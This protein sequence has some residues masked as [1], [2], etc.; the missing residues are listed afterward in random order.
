MDL[1]RC[2]DLVTRLDVI[3]ARGRHA[4]ALNACRP[5]FV[6]PPGA[7]GTMMG[8]AVMGSMEE[9]ETAAEAAEAARAAEEAAMF[10][11][12]G[13]PGSVVGGGFD[14]YEDEDEDEDDE[15]DGYS[16]YKGEGELL[17]ELAGLRQPVLAAQA[18]KA[19]A[20]ARRAAAAKASSKKKRAGAKEDD[21]ADYDDELLLG[22]RRGAGGRDADGMYDS[23]APRIRGPVPVD[24]F[25]PLNT[26]S[27]VITGPNTGGKTAAMKA[28]G[29]AALM[30]RAGLFVPA[31]VAN[32]PWFD[33]VL[34]DI[35]DSQDL[36]QS[37]STFSAR[38]AKQRAILAAANT[39]SLVLMDEVGTGT[40]PA[41]GAAIG[42]ALL[43]QL[44]GVGVESFGSGA[45]GLTLATTHHGELKAL[46]YEHKGG[47]FENAAV[48]F[49]EVALAPTYRLLWGVPGR[50][51]ALQIAERFGLDPE[52]VA[53][54]RAALGEGRVTLEETISALESA[55]RGADE[56]IA[57]ARSLL[58]EVSRTVPRVAAAAA[59]VRAA[60]EAADVKLA[61]I[62]AR[63]ARERRVELAA[64]ARETARVNA[65]EKRASTMKSGAMDF[66]TAA[67]AA[68]AAEAEAKRLAAVA[69]RNPA[70]SKPPPG[71]IPNV[72]DAVIITS[73]GMSG[74]VTAVSGTLITVQAG[75]M[76]IKVNASDAEPD[77]E[78]PK[79]K[80]PP[81]KARS[82]AGTQ[83]ARRMDAL[84]GGHRSGGGGGGGGGRKGGSNSA[85][86]STMSGGGGGGGGFGGYDFDD[87]DDDVPTIGDSV[88]I[89]K[90]GVV[91]TVVDADDGVL[92]VQAGKNRLKAPTGAV[93]YANRGSGVKGIS[94]GGGGGGGGGGVGGG[95]GGGGGFGGGGSKGSKK[96]K[97]KGGGSGLPRGTQQ[98]DQKPGGPPSGGGGGGGG[99]GGG[100]GGGGGKNGDIN[101]LMDKFRRK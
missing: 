66:A 100:G 10:P 20:A 85:A 50:S 96:K 11:T 98:A 54:A 37:L 57:A 61:A 91:G 45:A 53:D 51:R 2:L 81:A 43:E 36:M 59:R 17:V 93:E 32:L 74:K 49:D 72:G 6:I 86:S 46:K 84:L 8:G 73:T 65:R 12:L 99:R 62:V 48:E 58:S 31:E 15:D 26:R 79:P 63:L 55:R 64:A 97:K 33:A 4:A 77:T 101:A 82:P 38:L 60:E 25:V 7:G 44:A 9:E 68:A 35:G 47:V 19:Q 13:P 69:A 56:D 16:S 95:G 94:V 5:K 24:V 52:V 83:A 30:A 28:V 80:L 42:G 14:N 87:G 34:V 40:S 89:K 92:T 70:A 41:E 71:W 27:V 29:L 75:L 3:A 78:A 90:S 1:F 22:K 76:G 39:R 67:A 18:I 88:R 23:S 21:D